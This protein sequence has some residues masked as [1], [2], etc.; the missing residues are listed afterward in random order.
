M[1]FAGQINFTDLIRNLDI[2]IL[3]DFINRR[4]E[5]LG[6]QLNEE[7]SFYRLENALQEERAQIEEKDRVYDAIAARVLPQSREIARLCR[8]AG[9]DEDA[10]E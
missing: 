6:E 3:I 5:E 8:E 1:L 4:L 2:R 10:E 7:T 9:E